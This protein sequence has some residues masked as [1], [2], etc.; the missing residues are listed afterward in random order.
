MRNDIFLDVVTRLVCER[1]PL[2]YLRLFFVTQRFALP[3]ERSGLESCTIFM[4]NCVVITL[5]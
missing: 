1:D 4:N 3:A 5:L 2:K